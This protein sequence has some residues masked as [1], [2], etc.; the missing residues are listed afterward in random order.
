MIVNGHTK[1]VLM[2][3]TGAVVE[4]E[5]EVA[6]DSLPAAGFIEAVAHLFEGAPGFLGRL[7]IDRPYGSWWNLLERA[8][9]IAQAMPEPEQVQ[10][11]NAHPRLGAPPESV[12]RLSFSEQGYDR[13]A[14]PEREAGVPLA[15]ANPSVRPAWGSAAST[16]AS[17]AGASPALSTSG[18]AHA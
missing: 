8:R 18:I 17:P 6:L 12:S 16:G 15:G 10:L 4:V 11:L 3:P 13:V 2:D 7:A 9:V 1:D 14:E 5:E